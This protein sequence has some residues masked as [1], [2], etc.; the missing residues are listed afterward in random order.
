MLK[1]KWH[2][3]VVVLN[4]SHENVSFVSMLSS[5][6]EKYTSFKLYSNNLVATLL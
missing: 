6:T 4:P 3:R 5:N 2:L 1:G